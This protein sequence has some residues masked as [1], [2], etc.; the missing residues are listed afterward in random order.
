MIRSAG[1]LCFDRCPTGFILCPEI[2]DFSKCRRLST[3]ETG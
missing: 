1:P 2:L 3:F